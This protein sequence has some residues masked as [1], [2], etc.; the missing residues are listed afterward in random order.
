MGD[1]YR[2]T[3]D[4][5]RKWREGRKKRKGEQETL[6]KCLKRVGT[7]SDNER[8]GWEDEEKRGRFILF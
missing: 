8:G 1:K 5:I 4:T 7:R 2:K 3:M 6:D